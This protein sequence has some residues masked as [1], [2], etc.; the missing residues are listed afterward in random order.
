MAGSAIRIGIAGHRHGNPR[1]S[2]HVGN[3]PRRNVP[4]DFTGNRGIPVRLSKEHF[5]PQGIVVGRQGGMTRSGN[6]YKQGGVGRVAEPIRIDASAVENPVVG[7]QHL[8]HGHVRVGK[9]GITTSQAGLEIGGQEGESGRRRVSRGV[10]PVPQ[11]HARRHACFVWIVTRSDEG[12]SL[13]KRETIKRV[14]ETFVLQTSEW[15][16]EFVW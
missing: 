5:E 2:R 4:G 11:I 8:C 6:L 14:S 13:S 12:T 16:N 9:G 10:V 15:M 3:G 7:C 1:A